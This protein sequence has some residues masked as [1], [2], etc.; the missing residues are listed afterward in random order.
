MP[1]W[2]RQYRPPR[3]ELPL[4]IAALM[5][6]TGENCIITTSLPYIT[7]AVC[8]DLGQNT[9]VDFCLHLN[10]H[11]DQSTELQE[12]SVQ[13]SMAERVSSSVPAVLLTA[14]CACWIDRCGPKPLFLLPCLGNVLSVVCF[15][16][17]LLHLVPHVPVLAFFGTGFLIKALSGREVLF[18]FISFTY[19][20]D[21]VHSSG[22]YEEIGAGIGGGFEYQTLLENRNRHV[23]DMGKRDR[24]K[25]E[26]DGFH[27]RGQLLAGVCRLQMAESLGM[28]LGALL[29]WL[30]QK[31]GG[32]LL[33]FLVGAVISLLGMLVVVCFMK[34]YRYLNS[35]DDSATL[36][37]SKKVQNIF[38]CRSLDIDHVTMWGCFCVVLFTSSY[39]AGHTTL[40]VPFLQQPPLSWPRERYSAYAA[41]FNAFQAILFFVSH[42]IKPHTVVVMSLVLAT[43]GGVWTA[44]ATTTRSM[45]VSGCLSRVVDLISPALMTLLCLHL[46]Q[47]QTSQVLFRIS[48]AKSLSTL[49]GP[50]MFAQ[51]YAHT[52]DYYTGMVFLITAGIPVGVLLV[53]AMVEVFYS[54][55]F[56]SPREEDLPVPELE[57]RDASRRPA[58]TQSMDTLRPVL[59]SRDCLWR[60]A[61]W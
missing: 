31:F 35:N 42:V 7:F 60:S 4:V 21:V 22:S 48:L 6:F 20:A 51:L 58:Y 1:V 23:R 61:E 8:R 40:I 24:R 56:K 17:A 55:G 19:L 15:I 12:D 18:R 50:P 25:R 28:V 59:S 49:I 53:G 46:H 30:C 34:D 3:K 27:K 14:L 52:K 41:S 44:F 11:P 10:Q 36:G 9:S 45:L 29:S 26:A 37:T 39:R 54:L 16:L 2:R 43:A 33:A 32:A 5:Y 47:N 57:A 38:S 13:W